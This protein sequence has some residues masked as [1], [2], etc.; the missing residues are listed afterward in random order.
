M[1]QKLMTSDGG[2]IVRFVVGVG[3]MVFALANPL[4]LTMTVVVGFAGLTLVLVALS[5][6]CPLFAVNWARA[7]KQFFGKGDSRLP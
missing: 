3:L 4:P 2:R 7:A 5:G 1:V 6:A